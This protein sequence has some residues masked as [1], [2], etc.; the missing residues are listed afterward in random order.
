MVVQSERPR[1]AS[2]NVELVKGNLHLNGKLV[3][4]SMPRSQRFGMDGSF[5]QRD[6]SSVMFDR[7][8]LPGW[9]VDALYARPEYI[10]ESWQAHRTDGVLSI[11][12]WATIYDSGGPCVRFLRFERPTGWTHGFRALSR[13]W[14][15]NDVAALV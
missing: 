12:F 11:F 9:L 2:Y 3:S 6:M 8:V 13:R 14:K 5:L 4:L 7:R 10:P 1:P 15:H